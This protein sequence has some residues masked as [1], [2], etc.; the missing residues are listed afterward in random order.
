MGYNE[1]EMDSSRSTTFYPLS[2]QNRMI[3]DCTLLHNFIRHEME[4]DPA[5]AQIHEDHHELSN[6]D[7]PA[8][9]LQM[10]ATESFRTSCRDRKSVACRRMWTRTEKDLL[11]HALKEI[12]TTSWKADNEFRVD[13][14]N[15]LQDKIMKAEPTVRAMRYKSWPYYDS[16]CEI[17]G[18]DRTNGNKAE[19][20]NDPF[21]SV[22]HTETQPQ[23]PPVTNLEDID[24]SYTLL[25]K[26][27]ATSPVCESG[28]ST[29]TKPASKGKRKLP[30]RIVGLIMEGLNNS[31]D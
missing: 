12:L 6:D 26:E 21:V 20:F 19:D 10:V 13:Y 27:V 24:T 11:I 9:I 29:T 23:S 18:K 14:L 28:S 2:T 22:M 1:M 16:W 8:E 15:V 7:H 4:V 25:A 3:L 17:F 31:T 5:E 30:K